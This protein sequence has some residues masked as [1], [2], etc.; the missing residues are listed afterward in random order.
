MDSQKNTISTEENATVEL[1]L[2]SPHFDDIILIASKG[3]SDIPVTS[4]FK[5]IPKKQIK[6]KYFDL[7]HPKTHCVKKKDTMPHSGNI[8]K[9]TIR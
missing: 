6:E 7:E 1:V 4:R 9:E 5:E 3:L 2:C 8:L